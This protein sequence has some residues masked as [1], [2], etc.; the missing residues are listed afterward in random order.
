[1]ENFNCCL[2]IY[3]VVSNVYVASIPIKLQIVEKTNLIDLSAISI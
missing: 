1:M 2:S 3:I